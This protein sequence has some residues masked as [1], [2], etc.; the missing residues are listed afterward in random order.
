[1]WAPQQSETNSC[2]SYKMFHLVF[3]IH[4]TMSNKF[5]M[6]PKKFKG[7]QSTNFSVAFLTNIDHNILNG[8]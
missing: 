5:K 4:K 7:A 1:M 2:N 6:W 3:I 8:Y